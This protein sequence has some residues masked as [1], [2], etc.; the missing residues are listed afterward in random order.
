MATIHQIIGKVN[1]NLYA[2][3]KEELLN[4][5]RSLDKI[6]ADEI[7]PKALEQHTIVY[8]SSSETLEPIYFFILDL[9]NDMRLSP[10]KITDN[11]TSSPGSGHFSELGQRATVMQSQATKIL[12]DINNV[13]RSMLNLIYDLKEFKIRLETYIDLKSKNKDK[14]EAAR[15]S[16]KRIWMDRVDINK[17][18]SA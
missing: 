10:E 8:D 7:K 3:N 5:Y 6:P 13:V 2:E 14:A 16:L 12:G 4:K 15:L 18:N 17:G 11:F 1:P 9:M